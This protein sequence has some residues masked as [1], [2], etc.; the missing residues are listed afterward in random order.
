[1]LIVLIDMFIRLRIRKR[2]LGR[3]IHLQN[4]SIKRASRFHKQLFVLML[5]SIIIF[6]TTTLPLAIYRI[7]FPKEVLSMPVEEYGLVMSISAILT[8]FSGFNYAV[9]YLFFSRIKC[10]EFLFRLIFIFIV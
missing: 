1:M 7:V 2:S 8:W 10:K 6:L 3:R 9:K 4:Q 5:S